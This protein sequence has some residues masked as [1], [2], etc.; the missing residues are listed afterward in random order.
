MNSDKL[1]TTIIQFTAIVGD[2]RGDEA[3]DNLVGV[4]GVSWKFVDTMPKHKYGRDVE[5]ILMQFAIEGAHKWFKMPTGYKLGPYGAKQKGMRFD[6]PVG[7]DKLQLLIGTEK[8]RAGLFSEIF[9]AL[10]D[11]I[12]K[13]RFP[14][15]IDFDKETFLKDLN[16]IIASLRKPWKIGS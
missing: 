1:D 5:F 13:R 4:D 7:E 15:H 8:E 11:A 16:E 10:A 3:F 14:D 6:V 12:S 9:Q 2:E